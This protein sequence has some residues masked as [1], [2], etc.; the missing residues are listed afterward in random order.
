MQNRISWQ[1]DI[2][3]DCAVPRVVEAFVELLGSAWDSI[4][5]ECSNNSSENEITDKIVSWMQVRLRSE[6]W[7]VYQQAKPPR[8]K[9]DVGEKTYGFCD[10]TVQ[11]RSKPIIF[12][13]KRLNIYSGGRFASL[14]TPYVKEGLHRFLF[15]YPQNGKRTPQYESLDGASGMIGYVMDSAVGSAVCAVQKS[16]ATYATPES[17]VYP[18]P[19]ACPATNS[20]RFL[21]THSD[22]CNQ[23]VTV[24]HILL[25]LSGD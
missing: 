23:R 11:I 7:W 22:C 8:A 3:L 20:F 17:Q 6:G 12:E 15:P 16:L 18:N 5:D 24:H 9:Y 19:P 25:P 21:T 2:S 1:A 10:I 14:A 13:C 4:K